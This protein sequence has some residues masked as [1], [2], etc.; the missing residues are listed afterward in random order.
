MPRGRPRGAGRAGSPGQGGG[1]EGPAGRR[2]GGVRFPCP[3]GR[4]RPSVREARD[5]GPPAPRLGRGARDGRFPWAPQAPEPAGA[6][7]RAA[8]SLTLTPGRPG[9]PCGAERGHSLSPAA[10]DTAR[11]SA[12]GAPGAE[13]LSW[14]PRGPSAARGPDPPGARQLRATPTDQE[15][16]IFNLAARPVELISARRSR[17][18]RRPGASRRVPPRP[19]SRGTPPGPYLRPAGSVRRRPEG[20]PRAFHV[21]LREHMRGARAAA[22]RGKRPLMARGQGP[23]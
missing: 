10:G 7:E 21:N 9:G 20:F 1:A 16:L 17:G 11:P 12:A 23:R 3:P 4:H 5:A 13:G 2:V 14:A 8:R 6:A 22:S 15:P 18:G 19:A